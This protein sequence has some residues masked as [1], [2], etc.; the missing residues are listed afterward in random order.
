M[1]N[2]LALGPELAHI[3]CN[4][5]CSFHQLLLLLSLTGLKEANMR[6]ASIVMPSVIAAGLHP[7]MGNVLDKCSDKA[8]QKSSPVH[9]GLLVNKANGPARQTSPNHSLS[10]RAL[11]ILTLAP[12]RVGPV[13]AVSSETIEES[14][15]I[16]DW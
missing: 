14:R 1:H 4:I 15:Q 8:Q 3:L 16:L 6:W 7:A 13:S 9:A 10:S 11:N 12:Y 5:G 2:C